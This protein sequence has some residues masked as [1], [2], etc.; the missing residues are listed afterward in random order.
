M[1]NAGIHIRP[2]RVVSG[3]LRFGDCI[4]IPISMLGKFSSPCGAN[5]SNYS[6]CVKIEVSTEYDFVYS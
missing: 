6:T 5:A 3:T 1:E 4:I 2:T